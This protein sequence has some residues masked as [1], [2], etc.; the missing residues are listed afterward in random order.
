M[1]LKEY[2]IENNIS[3]DE[4]KKVYD[5]IQEEMDSRKKL[6]AQYKVARDRY[7]QAGA[8]LMIAYDKC[9]GRSDKSREEY[10]KTL[11]SRIS[12]DPRKTMTRYINPRLMN[13]Q[14]WDALLQTWLSK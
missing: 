14:D 7:I 4:I 5:E 6:Y 1:T 3:E 11:E 13:D 9:F 10:V 8:D 2:I 12:K